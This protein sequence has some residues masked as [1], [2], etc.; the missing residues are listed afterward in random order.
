ME[1]NRLIDI[2]LTLAHQEKL[3]DE[4][5]Q[6]VTEQQGRIDMLEERCRTLAERLRSFGGAP[7]GADD[8][9]RPPHY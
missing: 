7:N 3:L 9:E 1:E 5:N 8:R 2:E 6:L 4:L